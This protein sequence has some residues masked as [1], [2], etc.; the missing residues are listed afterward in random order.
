MSTEV[1][2]LPSHQLLPAPKV[3]A[4]FLASSHF[5]VAQE[6][7]VTQ[8]S[9]KSIFKKDY[10]PHDVFQRPD[11]SVPPPPAD[12]M[13]K[14]DRYFNNKASETVKSYPRKNLHKPELRNVY[15]ALSQT[16]FK[17]DSDLGKFDS[18]HTTHN[19]YFIPQPDGAV[20]PS[21]FK[22][23][24][25]KSFIPQGDPEKSPQPY[26]D[27]KDHYRGHDTSLHVID[28]APCMH[29]GGLPTI[30]GDGRLH[31]FDTTHGDT[32]RGRWLPRIRSL[33]AV[34]PSIFSFSII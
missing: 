32:F 18:F 13:H 12:V 16:N 25:M 21:K 15:A 34:S 22:K 10:I 27:Y 9:L 3:G 20:V 29:T 7:R 11:A 6:P 24:R 31:Q 33:S 28:K 30:T 17:M 23:D 1:S 5:A 14:D 19:M 8:K 4:E 2:S 26:S